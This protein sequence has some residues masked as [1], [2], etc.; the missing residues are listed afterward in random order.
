[1]VLTMDRLLADPLSQ[2]IPVDDGVMRSTQQR[3]ADELA[4]GG[5]DQTGDSMAHVKGILLESSKRYSEVPDRRKFGDEDE[6]ISDTVTD[7]LSSA[8]HKRAEA[9]RTYFKSLSRSADSKIDVKQLRRAEAFVNTCA[10]TAD[11]L[12]LALAEEMLGAVFDTPSPC[13]VALRNMQSVTSKFTPLLTAPTADEYLTARGVTRAPGQTKVNQ[14]LYSIDRVEGQSVICDVKLAKNTFTHRTHCVIGPGGIGKT[15]GLCG[16]NDGDAVVVTQE[17]KSMKA[18]GDTPAAAAMRFVS[19]VLAMLAEGIP[20]TYAPYDDPDARETLRR[21]LALLVADKK[22]HLIV[23]RPWTND[24][25]EARWHGT[26]AKRRVAPY[27]RGINGLGDIPSESNKAWYNELAAWAEKNEGH[28]VATV[29]EAQR[30]MYHTARGVNKARIKHLDRDGVPTETLLFSYRGPEDVQDGIQA[31]PHGEDTLRENALVPGMMFDPFSIISGYA[32]LD[33]LKGKKAPIA[34]IFA[35]ALTILPASVAADP[36]LSEGTLVEAM[37]SWAAGTPMRIKNLTRKYEQ[38]L[39]V[40]FHSPRGTYAPAPG[41]EP[42]DANFC[43]EAGDPLGWIEDKVKTGLARNKRTLEYLRDAGAPNIPVVGSAEHE[44]VF[45]ELAS[46]YDLMPFVWARTSKFGGT[47]IPNRNMAGCL[48]WMMHACATFWTFDMAPAAHWVAPE[49]EKG[50]TGAESYWLALFKGYA[51]PDA[52]LI[53]KN[54]PY[55]GSL[56]M[57][58]MTRGLDDVGA[59]IDAAIGLDSSGHPSIENKYQTRPKLVTRTRDVAYMANVVDCTLPDTTAALASDDPLVHVENAVADKVDGPDLIGAAI[60]DEYQRRMHEAETTLEKWKVKNDHHAL[61]AFDVRFAMFLGFINVPSTSGVYGNSTTDANREG[62]GNPQPAYCQ[63]V[64]NGLA[65]KIIISPTDA[66]NAKKAEGD[67]AKSGGRVKARI[68]PKDEKSSL[69]LGRGKAAGAF[70]TRTS[71]GK[72]GKR[73]KFQSEYFEVKKIATNDKVTVGPGLRTEAAERAFDRGRLNYGALQAAMISATRNSMGKVPREIF[74]VHQ[75]ALAAETR[76][77]EA[78]KSF[79]KTTGVF[80]PLVSKYTVGTVIGFTLWL[81]SLSD[82]ERRLYIVMM[83]DYS[84]FDQKLGVCMRV[85][86]NHLSKCIGLGFDY[87]RP[88]SP[89]YSQM[90]HGLVTITQDWGDRK[91]ASIRTALASGLKST[92][93]IGC[94]FH[95]ALNVVFFS[96]SDRL[97]NGEVP[98]EMREFLVKH[99]DA[100]EVSSFTLDTDGVVTAAKKDGTMLVLPPPGNVGKSEREGPSPGEDTIWTEEVW[101]GYNSLMLQSMSADATKLVDIPNLKGWTPP[102]IKYLG[103][104]V[105]TGKHWVFGD[106]GISLGRITITLHTKKIRNVERDI[107]IGAIGAKL[108]QAT[109]NINMGT[110]HDDPMETSDGRW[111]FMLSEGMEDQLT[112]KRA[113]SWFQVETDEERQ[114]SEVTKTILEGMGGVSTTAAVINNMIVFDMCGDGTTVGSKATGTKTETSALAPSMGADGSIAEPISPFQLYQT[115]MGNLA[116]PRADK[117]IEVSL[118]PERF[119]IMDRALKWAAGSDFKMEV[120]P[121]QLPLPNI[122]HDMALTDLK[123]YPQTYGGISGLYSA[124]NSSKLGTLRG[125]ANKIADQVEKFGAVFGKDEINLREHFANKLLVYKGFEVYFT[126]DYF[127]IWTDGD[128]KGGVAKDVNGE[129]NASYSVRHATYNPAETRTEEEPEVTASD[130]ALRALAELG[131]TWR[132]DVPKGGTPA[133]FQ[134]QTLAPYDVTLQMLYDSDYF[135]SFQKRTPGNR[136]VAAWMKA[137][138]VQPGEETPEPEPEPASEAPKRKHQWKNKL[139]RRHPI[140]YCF[141]K[142]AEPFAATMM[143]TGGQLSY[144]RKLTGDR[145]S[146]LVIDKRSSGLS[147]LDAIKALGEYRAWRKNGRHVWVFE[148]AFHANQISP[149]DGTGGRLPYNKGPAWLRAESLNPMQENSAGYMDISQDERIQFLQDAGCADRQSIVRALGSIAQDRVTAKILTPSSALTF[150]NPHM[151][152]WEDTIHPLCDVL[153]EESLPLW[154]ACTDSMAAILINQITQTHCLIEA[155]G[156]SPVL[157]LLK[158]GV[159]LGRVPGMR[160]VKYAG[161]R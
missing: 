123:A 48:G 50:L 112:Y 34:L 63:K 75:C 143:I 56:R 84:K 92:S 30:I 11:P 133:S 156:G 142:L 46:S 121:G 94:F 1:M 159:L 90:G 85:L 69:V 147:E 55:H 130:R 40:H 59:S 154:Q 152:V 2:D 17:L 113:L 73:V 23:V 117:L 132:P 3:L 158:P 65:E 82:E 14:S 60:A 91:V 38:S 101:K 161:D 136:R 58:Q 135:T 4:G 114:T 54:N 41:R 138:L 79:G 141:S 86:S 7:K 95:Y 64:M 107:C 67:K 33:K 116:F 106:D 53:V 140:Q 15:V 129:L 74:P 68:K 12:K 160:I 100:V 148:E 98:L 22:L 155:G 99:P 39:V 31:C 145:F 128:G 103:A 66:T 150:L 131:T 104:A 151:R 24:A 26:L 139:L 49:A 122:W 157:S 127:E 93:L 61:C 72:D 37:R 6:R 25:A 118:A 21:G 70:S 18:E 47:T 10:D 71:V 88:V 80:L 81:Q 16:V 35:A 119:D 89:I 28:A 42:L 102:R 87:L 62:R 111:L 57:A 97:G 134:E 76:V 43:V 45:K 125:V 109:T 32:Y 78:L 77:A 13:P 120:L 51:D 44:A 36:A 137:N 9:G 105:S 27:D 83:D 110:K 149:A 146:K 108:S 153:D 52:G 126:D 124:S 96:L 115:A 20:M 19:G 144:E 5:E 29:S 8:M